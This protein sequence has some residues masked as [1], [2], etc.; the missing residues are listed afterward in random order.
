MTNKE[1]VPVVESIIEAMDVKLS[2][3]LIETVIIEVSLG[4]D[5]KTGIDW[6]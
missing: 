6:V 3:V 1:L 5:L 2:Q 4:D